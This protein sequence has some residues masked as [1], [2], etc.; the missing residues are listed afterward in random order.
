MW[1]T[2]EPIEGALWIEFESNNENENTAK[3]EELY[4]VLMKYTEHD[5]LV[6]QTKS[7]IK[8]L[9]EYRK[10]IGVAAINN[11]DFHDLDIVVPRS[12]NADMYDII[13]HVCKSL[14]LDYIVIGHIGDGNFHIN[15]FRDEK[16]NVESWKEKIKSCIT[17]LFK[18]VVELGGE[19]SG[20]H[21]IGTH[22][23]PYFE[24]FT[25]QQNLNIMKGI[26][27]VFDPKNTLNSRN[28]F[29][30]D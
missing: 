8:T 2:K 22:N 28:I 1:T 15:I 19:I 4:D 21:G 5:I 20:E 25:A 11:G 29:N 26:K 27:K 3:V 17:I 9:W 12:K 13:S 18:K 7:E 23:K 10:K 30:K 6:G 24:K 16:L 14:E